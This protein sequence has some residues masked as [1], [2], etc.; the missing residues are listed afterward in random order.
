MV[1]CMCA[2]ARERESARRT[3]IEG[4]AI[5]W[6]WRTEERLCTYAVGDAVSVAV[7]PDGGGGLVSWNS[8]LTHE[9]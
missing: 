2:C 8:V 3:L 7:K 6:N 1:F 9:L 4:T 5:L